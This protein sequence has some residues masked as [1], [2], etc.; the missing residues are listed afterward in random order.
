MDNSPL[1]KLPAEL[2]LL[3]YEQTLTFEPA[4]TVQLLHDPGS[5]MTIRHGL[6]ITT[7]CKE[8][9]NECV[10]L[11]FKHNTWRF[12]INSVWNHCN[13]GPGASY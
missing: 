13:P 5:H 6:E 4:L 3:I 11:V 7:T 10:N 9:H 2:R 12:D 1:R 8:I